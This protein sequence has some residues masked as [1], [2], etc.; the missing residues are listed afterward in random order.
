M[1]QPMYFV[2]G[3]KVVVMIITSFNDVRRIRLTDK[4]SENVKPSW[5]G[6]SIGHYE[7]DTL[8]IDTV[9]IKIGPHAMLDM[10]GTPHTD[11]LHVVERYRILDYDDAK[12]AIERGFKE[13]WRVAGGTDF[14]PNYRGKV[15][16]LHFTI[17]DEGVFTTPWTATI[18]YQPSSLEWSELICSENRVEYYHGEHSTESN[19]PTAA[20]PDF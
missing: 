12:D 1:T 10:Y 15:L 4:H 5:Y 19:V 9:G 17:E 2:Q 3:P 7:G 20:K 16:Q 13:N 14:N 18:T 6:D 8:V 11:K